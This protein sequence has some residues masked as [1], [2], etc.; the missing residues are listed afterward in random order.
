MG[1]SRLQPVI[2]SSRLQP[3]RVPPKSTEEHNRDVDE[4]IDVNSLIGTVAEEALREL[5]P[6]QQ[7]KAIGT[8]GG[9]YRSLA[10]T[11]KLPDK[12]RNTVAVVMSRVRTIQRQAQTA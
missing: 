4:F 11:L 10:N 3:V 12:I 9:A 2:G 6:E 5:P 8:D 1:S 7:K